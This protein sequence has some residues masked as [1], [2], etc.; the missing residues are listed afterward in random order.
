MAGVELEEIVF[1]WAT[2]SCTTLG[3]TDSSN[4]QRPDFVHH[5]EYSK[6]DTGL[7]YGHG[8]V[9]NTQGARSP[10]SDLAELHELLLEVVLVALGAACTLYGV[11]F[12]MENPRANL[13]M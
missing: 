8:A 4:S 10:T 12:A 9:V 5:Q 1:V 6:K 11:H 7:T 3:A 13:R 2:V